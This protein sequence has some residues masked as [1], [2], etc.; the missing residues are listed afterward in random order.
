MRGGI[1]TTVNYYE[2]L[3][4]RPAAEFEELR[5]AYRARAMDCH[6]DRF[7]GDPAKHAAFVA[8]GEAFN[9]LSDPVRRRHH[10]LAMGPFSG[11]GGATP[12]H[13][14]EVFSE[15]EDAILDTVQDDILE[16]LI[17]GNVVPRETSLQTL[18][19]DLEQ[20]EP[21]CLFREAKTRLYGGAT[22]VAEGL[23]RTYLRKAPINILARYF[24]SQCCAAN[25]SWREAER[26]LQIA[27]NIGDH[28]APPLRLVRLRRELEALR[29]RQPGWRGLL[30][31]LLTPRPKPADD[32]T[33]EDS[34]RRALNRAINRL[35][36]QRLHVRQPRGH[37]PSRSEAGKP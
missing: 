24:L 32:I 13:A 8:I 19:L 27:L 33:T 26:Q 10:D 2:V 22:V 23:F 17:V 34:E 37:L 1:V 31:R 18:M 25:G 14:T 3:G 5:K 30:W 12:M 7:E 36:A 4:V 9:V 15:D 11:P 20:T 29:D 35:A 21:F 28:R 16:E 6:P